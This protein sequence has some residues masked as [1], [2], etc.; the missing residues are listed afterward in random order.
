MLMRLMAFRSFV[1][2]PGTRKKSAQLAFL[3]RTQPLVLAQV[4]RAVSSVARFRISAR[5]HA[6]ALIQLELAVILEGAAGV[7]AEAR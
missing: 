1:G 7:G 2:S 5:R 4:A 6:G 3:D